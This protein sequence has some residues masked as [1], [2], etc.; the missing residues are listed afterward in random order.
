MSSSFWLLQVDSCDFSQ[1]LLKKE[2]LK[3]VN[4]N[5]TLAVHS[6]KIKEAKTHFGEKKEKNMASPGFEPTISKSDV[7]RANHYSIAQ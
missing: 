2:L 6:P 3:S 1:A 4:S 5:F 7:D